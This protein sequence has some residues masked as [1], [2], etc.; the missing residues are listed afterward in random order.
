MLVT[1]I[2]RD[3]AGHTVAENERE[4]VDVFTAL[5]EEVRW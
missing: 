5:E 4:P 2:M 3:Q 1:R